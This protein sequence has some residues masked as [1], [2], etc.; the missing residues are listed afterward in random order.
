MID[1]TKTDGA[2]PASAVALGFFDGLHLGHI[3]VIKAA[4]EYARKNA[5][6]SA[7]F[8]FGG[9]TLLPKFSVSENLITHRQK[10]ALL[11]KI[12]VD[13]IF[14]PDFSEVREMSAEQFVDDIL[15]KRLNSTAIVCG[16]D[17]RF[18]KGGKAGADMLAELCS[19]RGIK[20]EIIPPVTF[21]GEA[22]SSTAIRS[23][24]REGK[25]AEANAR[26]G[27]ELTYSL[28]VIHGNKLGRTIGSPTINQ[29]IPPT[30]VT[31]RFGVYKS[32][33]VIEGRSYPS[34]TNIGVKPTVSD[35]NAALMET[36]IVGFDGDLYDREISVIL[37]EFIREEQKFPSIDEL[38][39]NIQ[40]DI[41]S[42]SDGKEQ[43]WTR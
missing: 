29:I 25:I 18:G 9:E 14:A 20:T 34:I 17:F 30:S 24:V 5:C 31:P 23:L 8:T 38:K 1:I 22:I 42:L 4:L 26:L 37:R 6:K 7:V 28:P 16:Y 39:K 19:E 15:V 11:E 21:D 36:H 12:G 35:G 41:K 2:A 3:E 10:L 27:Y 13:Y 40:N 32:W 33:T 43:K